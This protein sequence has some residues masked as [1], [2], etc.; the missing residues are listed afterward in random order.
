MVL[1]LLA[2]QALTS[3]LNTSDFSFVCFTSM[4][5]HIFTLCFGRTYTSLNASL[6]QGLDCCEFGNLDACYIH[7]PTYLTEAFGHQAVISTWAVKAPVFFQLST[8]LEQCGWANFLWDHVELTPEVPR[9]LL[10][11]KNKPVALPNCLH[12]QRACQWGETSF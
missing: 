8:C 3:L 5:Q 11:R 2:G 1:I 10:I 6:G 7:N 9:K 4:F 12:F